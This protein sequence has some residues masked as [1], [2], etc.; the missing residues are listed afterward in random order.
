MEG[1]IN[2]RSGESIF[3]LASDADKDHI[4]LMGVSYIL[5]TFGSLVQAEHWYEDLPDAV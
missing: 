2:L 5:E 4:I 1:K 3:L